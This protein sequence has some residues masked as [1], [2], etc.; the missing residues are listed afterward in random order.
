MRKAL[1]VCVLVLASATV[2]VA[3]GR[4]EL[5]SRA[6]RSSSTSRKWTRAAGAAEVVADDNVSPGAPRRG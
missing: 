6:A 3:P 4:A 1:V 5:L 2:V